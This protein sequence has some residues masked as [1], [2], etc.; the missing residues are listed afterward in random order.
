MVF[1]NISAYELNTDDYDGYIK[2]DD[3]TLRKSCDRL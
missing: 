2:V 3:K 1:L